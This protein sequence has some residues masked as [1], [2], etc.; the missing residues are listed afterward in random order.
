M[1]N[2]RPSFPGDDVQIKLTVH[3]F[4]RWNERV[5]PHIGF[6]QLERL[7]NQ[8]LAIPNRIT[9]N[10]NKR[11]IIDSDILFVYEI[12]DQE[13]HIITF[14]GRASEQ[15]VLQDPRTFR[16]LKFEYNERL[17]LGLSEEALKK[18]QLPCIPVEYIQFDG[19]TTSYFLE[20]YKFQDGEES[21]S[22]IYVK[23]A[24]NLQLISS[25]EINP[26]NPYCPLLNRSVMYVLCVMGYSSFVQAHLEH[27]KPEEVKKAAE[28]YEQK[29]RE[30]A[31]RFLQEV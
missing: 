28:K 25:T 12:E 2:V 31:M 16:E 24:K 1:A 29:A 5:G 26:D 18:Q 9:M 11:A 23:E 27:H 22:I 20:R 4:K 8:L 17:N 21:G 30:R 15:P 6:A 19:R 7:L 10:S 13:I 3:A 14:I